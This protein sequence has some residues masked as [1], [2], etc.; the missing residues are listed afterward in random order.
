MTWIGEVLST[1]YTAFA[2]LWMSQAYKA[3][4]NGGRSNGDTYEEK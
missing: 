4:K 1:K 2:G 3:F